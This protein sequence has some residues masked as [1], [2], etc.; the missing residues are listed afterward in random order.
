M[1]DM[2][3]NTIIFLSLFSKDQLASIRLRPRPIRPMIT[4]YDRM[5]LN[6][7]RLESS[8]NLVMDPYLR[9]IYLYVIKYTD[10][11]CDH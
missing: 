6:F 8:K 10:I 5:Y 7:V 2:S 11:I 4:I 1:V 3:G 9:K